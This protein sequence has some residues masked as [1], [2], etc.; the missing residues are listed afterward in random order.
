MYVGEESDN[1]LSLVLT[2]TGV[3][4]EKK[5]HYKEVLGKFDYFMVLQV[6]LS[7]WCLIIGITMKMHG[8]Q[9]FLHFYNPPYNRLYVIKTNLNTLVLL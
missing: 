2:S 5:Q 7:K 6:S 8:F 4:T 3:T 1:G 9:I